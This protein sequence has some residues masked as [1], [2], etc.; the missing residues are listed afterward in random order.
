MA[1]INEDFIRCKCS[2]AEFQE[3]RIVSLPKNIKKRHLG[4]TNIKQP[5][6]EEHFY[7]D[8]TKCGQRLDR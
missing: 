7:Y 3:I 8:C 2:N 6:V 5:I 4:E 1:V